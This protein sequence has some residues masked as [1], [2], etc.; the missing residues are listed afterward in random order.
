MTNKFLF[1]LTLLSALGC[2]LIGGVFFAFSTFV[3]RA[4][5]ALPTPQGIAAMKSIN[6]AV[7]NPM[8]LGV[9]LGTAVGCVILVVSALLTWQQPGAACILVGSALYLLGTFLVTTIFNVPRNDA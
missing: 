2:G 4:L 6:I 9:F 3:M 1:A 7:I 5:A 8:F